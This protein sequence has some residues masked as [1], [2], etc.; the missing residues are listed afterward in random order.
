MVPYLSEVKMRVSDAVIEILKL[1]FQLA[2]EP[3]PT[4]VVQEPVE[5]P[6]PY[7]ISGLS[8][9]FGFMLCVLS[10]TLMTYKTQMKNASIG[11][12][13]DEHLR[14]RLQPEDIDSIPSSETKEE[15]FI[16]DDCN[17]IECDLH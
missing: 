3:T 15:E 9:I 13:T 16:H 2:P 17:F 11:T 14:Y 6:N 10:N 5:C 7:M 8:T 12:C 4:C 1:Y